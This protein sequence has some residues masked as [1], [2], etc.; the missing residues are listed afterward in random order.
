[1]YMYLDAIMKIQAGTIQHVNV[2]AVIPM[3]IYVVAIIKNI[4]RYN[5][6]CSL[7]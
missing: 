5:T 7:I 4:I 1:M 3:Y 2:R 6:A